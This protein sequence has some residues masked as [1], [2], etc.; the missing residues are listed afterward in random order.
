MMSLVIGKTLI[1]IYDKNT[2]HYAT[3]YIRDKN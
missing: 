1:K 2:M 3:T